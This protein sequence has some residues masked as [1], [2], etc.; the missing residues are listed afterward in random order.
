MD[1]PEAALLKTPARRV[2]ADRQSSHVLPNQ[3]GAAFQAFLFLGQHL[4]KILI[5]TVASLHSINN[6]VLI[7]S[8]NMRGSCHARSGSGGRDQVRSLPAALS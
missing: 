6:L 4:V 1:A 5:L 8:V 2:F 3:V 7:L